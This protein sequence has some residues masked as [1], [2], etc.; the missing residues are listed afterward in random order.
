MYRSKRLQA[1]AAVK[2][3]V[4]EDVMDRINNLTNSIYFS[5]AEEFRTIKQ[6]YKEDSSISQFWLG[7]CLDVSQT[8]VIDT[9]NA[10]LSPCFQQGYQDYI[11]DTADFKHRYLLGLIFETVGLKD[12]YVLEYLNG[13]SDGLILSQIGVNR[14]RLGNTVFYRIRTGICT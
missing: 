5:I 14:V 2:E 9:S 7:R 10:Y 8:G 6:F 1:A 12:P 4:L 13:I 3:P 11:Y